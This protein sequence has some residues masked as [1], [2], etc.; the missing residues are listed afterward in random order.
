MIIQIIEGIGREAQR[1]IDAGVATVI[2]FLEG[3]SKDVVQF[4]TAAFDIV[5]NTLHA[6]AT[7]IRTRGPELESA[8]KDL[9]G[10]I[11]DGFTMGWASK[12]KH[13]LDAI[14]DFVDEAKRKLTHP[15]EIFSPSHF[16]QRVGRDIMLGF[17]MGIENNTHEGVGAIEDFV[18]QSTEAFTNILDK[19]SAS[20]GETKDFN[21]LLLQY[22]I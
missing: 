2:K 21:P 10:A 6:L 12:A 16:T 15:W 14:G 1:I 20:L 19:A 11:L 3:V 9:V 22:L 13:A 4:A 18:V 5:T 7:V 8:G 17:A